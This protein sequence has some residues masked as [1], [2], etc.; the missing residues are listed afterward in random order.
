MP[1]GRVKGNSMTDQPSASILVVDDLE[2]KH[3]GYRTI[4]EELGEPVVCVSSGREALRHLLVKDFAVILMDVNMP[5]MDGFETAALI[6]QRRKDQHTPIIFI[7]A[8]ADE[9]QQAQGYSR[10]AVDYILSPVVPEILCAKVKVFVDLYRMRAELTRSNTLLEQ[11]VAERTA[12]LSATNE[13]LQ[14]EIIERQRAE[15]RLNLLV[16]ELSHRVKNLITV[17]QAIVRR[18]VVSGRTPEESREVLVNRLAAL[19]SAH[20]LLVEAN[21][22]GA[23]IDRVI[24]SEVIGFSERVNVTGPPVLLSALGS[25]NIA[26]LV[27]ELATNASKYGALSRP[28]GS[29][30]ILWSI[31]NGS[32][33]SLK[34]LWR[35]SGGP[36]CS[37]PAHKGFGLSL[38]DMIGTNLSSSPRLSFKSGGFEF[39]ASIPLEQIGAPERDAGP[40]SALVSPSGELG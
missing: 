29:I 2:E 11:R 16:G 33:R 19:G 14:R 37:P 22:Q 3:L 18:T 21:W 24:G 1:Q 10:G 12:D 35:E 7:T 39:E 25:Q 27:H 40:A 9:V 32:A 8:W 28:S 38:L 36:P 30:E 6:R 15:Q 13:R 26:L 23:P 4:L 20:D 34:F 31:D 5:G 17:I